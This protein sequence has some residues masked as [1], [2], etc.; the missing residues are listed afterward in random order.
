LTCNGVSIS[1]TWVSS[2]FSE[3]V[4]WG[5]QTF[6]WDT[7]RLAGGNLLA[8]GVSGGSGGSSLNGGSTMSFD[9]FD[10]AT[11]FQ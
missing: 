6:V 7:S 4:I 3:E 10:S 1:G 5:A 2:V 9:L 11:S 8:V